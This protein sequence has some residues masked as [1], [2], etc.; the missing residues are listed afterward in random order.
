MDDTYR[1]HLSC[2]HMPFSD[3]C[4]RLS[5]G[6]R[7]KLASAGLLDSGVLRGLDTDGGDFLEEA[8]TNGFFRRGPLVG[9]R[10]RGGV[11]AEL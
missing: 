7:A 11:F 5:N 1:T 3:L 8:Y 6:T 4:R 10:R 9:S 2:I